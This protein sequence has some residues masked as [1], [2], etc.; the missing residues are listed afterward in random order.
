VSDQGHSSNGVDP[1]TRL[2]TADE[3]ATR[4]Q[5]PTAHVYRLARDGKLP[6]VRLGKY[7]RFRAAEMEQFE[8]GGGVA[9]DA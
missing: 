8:A 1:S 3:L 5:V 7:V 2:L 4:W 6:T 9:A